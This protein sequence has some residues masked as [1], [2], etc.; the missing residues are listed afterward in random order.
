MIRPNEA[1]TET[2]KLDK[3]GRGS[4][5]IKLP[6]SMKN[7]NVL[8]EVVAGDQV[9]SQPFFAHS[10]DVKMMEILRSDSGQRRENRQ[11]NLK[12]VR[13]S[14]CSHERRHGFAS[15]RTAT[16]T[17]AGDLTTQRRAIVRQMESKSFR[18]LFS[19]AT[20]VRLLVRLPCRKSRPN[21]AFDRSDA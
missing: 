8:V 20:T 14:L 11:G 1:K 21:D 3:Q 18:S 2:L 5:T 12:N 19:Q 17:F 6:A 9:R 13:E 15:T 4:Q 10:L 7:K 16:P